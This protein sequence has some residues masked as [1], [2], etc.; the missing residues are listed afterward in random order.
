MGGVHEVTYGGSENVQSL[1]MG[2]IPFAQLQTLQDLQPSIQ[3]PSAEGDIGVCKQIG[4]QYLGLSGC[5]E[6]KN[7]V[8][9]Y[10]LNLY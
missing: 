6:L 7:S 8:V 2:Y 5:S 9:V 10:N 4:L 1:D 3:V